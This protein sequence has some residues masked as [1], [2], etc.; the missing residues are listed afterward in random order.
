MHGDAKTL[1]IKGELFYKACD[2]ETMTS[3]NEVGWIKT[4]L[5][6][7][8][9]RLGF[10]RVDFVHGPLE[11][12]RDIVMAD[13]DRFGVLKYYAIQAK[14]RD[15]RARSDSQE[16]NTITDQVRTAFET[17]YRDP[18]SGTEHKIAGVY[19]IINGSITDAARNI[20]YSK[21]GGWFNIVDISQ[22]ELAPLLLRNV[23]DDDRRMRLVAIKAETA[24][25]RLMLEI[26]LPQLRKQIEEDF[27][28]SLPTSAPAQNTI[29]R[30]LPRNWLS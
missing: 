6:P 5:L 13:F 27:G 20:L 8:F 28:L 19:L 4:H 21:I 3:R 29:P 26:F 16:I 1:Q 12:G 24:G 18:L 10:S 22:L 17:P 23:S 2:K 9:R 30:T 7:L 25:N 15:L 14:D 11:A